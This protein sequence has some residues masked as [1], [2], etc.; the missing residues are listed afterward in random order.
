MSRRIFEAR[1]ANDG[2]APGATLQECMALASMEYLQDRLLDGV[3]RCYGQPVPDELVQAIRKRAKRRRSRW[4]SLSKDRISRIV[5][6]IGEEAGIIVRT[7]DEERRIRVKYASAHD[8]RRSLAERLYNRG[9]TAETLM[10]IMRHRDFATTRKFYQ[11]K[12][13]AEAAAAEVHKLLAGDNAEQSTPQRIRT[14]PGTSEY[15]PEDSNL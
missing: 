4:T 12:K 14:C 10:V 6:A 13:R 15:T 11:A 9:M 1:R 3:V 8:L 7:P 2:L 5:S